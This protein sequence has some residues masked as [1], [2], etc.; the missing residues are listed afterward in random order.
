MKIPAEQPTPRV[1]KVELFKISDLIE[2][3]G[4]KDPATKEISEISS[5]EEEFHGFDEELNLLSEF[6]KNISD[7]TTST[8]Y[9]KQFDDTAIMERKRKADDPAENP[10]NEKRVSF[11]SNCDPEGLITDDEDTPSAT[12]PIDNDDNLSTPERIRK[13]A[14]ARISRDSGITSPEPEETLTITVCE[15]QNQAD[16]IELRRNSEDT[17]SVKSFVSAVGA[18]ELPFLSNH[19]KQLVAQAQEKYQQQVSEMQ[20]LVEKVNRW[21][22]YLKPILKASQERSEFD[23]HECGTEVLETFH[24]ESGQD[25]ATF[26]DVMSTKPEDHF[27]RFFLATLMLV[28]TGN[29]E[30]TNKNTDVNRIS[31]SSEIQLKLK[32]RVRLHEEIENMNETVPCIGQNSGAKKG[33]RKANTCISETIQSKKVKKQG[34]NSSTFS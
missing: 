18:P 33:K 8:P 32:S 16:S 9:K 20:T 28:N 34:K 12:K 1:F 31:E 25:E 10:P 11:G 5:D 13:A 29:L 6:N 19:D 17:D 30:L 24:E 23:I 27:A 2:R 22:Q 21:H 15:D 4:R 14:Q 7:L 3:N 26:A